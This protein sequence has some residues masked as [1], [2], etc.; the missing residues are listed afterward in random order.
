MEKCVFVDRDGTLGGDGHFCNPD[1][2]ELYDFSSFAIRML[3]EVGYKVIVITNQ[4]HIASG[5]ITREQ[6]DNSFYKIQDRLRLDGAHLDGWYVCPHGPYDGCECRKPL[7]YLLHKAAQDF[8]IDLANSYMIGDRGDSD[9]C[10][11][12]AAGCHPLLVLTGLGKNSYYE[13]RNTRKHVTPILVASNI[14][15]ATKSIIAP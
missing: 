14:E 2:F 3:N 1:K 8:N 10:A 13:F 5:G 6:V 9:M 11:A 7:P 15:E 12:D 4:S